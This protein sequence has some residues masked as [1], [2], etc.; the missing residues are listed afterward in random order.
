MINITC[1]CGKRPI[2]KRKPFGRENKMELIY[3]CP[4]GERGINAPTKNGAIYG[5]IRRKQLR[6]LINWRLSQ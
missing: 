4:C 5:W 3:E 2:L 6:E 1:Q